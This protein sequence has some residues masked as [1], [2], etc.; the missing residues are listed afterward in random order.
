VRYIANPLGEESVK[1]AESV[2]RRR[3]Y[4]SRGL[5]AEIECWARFMTVQANLTG[6]ASAH[7]ALGRLHVCR[8]SLWP[9]GQQMWLLRSLGR[10]INASDLYTAVHARCHPPHAG[11]EPDTITSVAVSF[12]SSFITRSTRA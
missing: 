4:K 7:H 8:C 3:S 2:S 6:L 11:S 5:V 9:L 10:E 1:M 12:T